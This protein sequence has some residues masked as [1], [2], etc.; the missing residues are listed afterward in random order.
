MLTWASHQKQP[1]SLTTAGYHSPHPYPY[2]KSI[3]ASAALFFSPIPWQVQQLYCRHKRASDPKML[4]S[5]GES[6]IDGAY[7]DSTSEAVCISSSTQANRILAPPHLQC[8]TLALL[9]PGVLL[10][11]LTELVQEWGSTQLGGT[12]SA[13][14]LSS[15][16]LP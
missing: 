7:T 1:Q 16:L 15:G 13:Q 8:H 12:R 11:R 14:T 5:R 4:L 3:Q 6:A 2:Q 10:S 9:A